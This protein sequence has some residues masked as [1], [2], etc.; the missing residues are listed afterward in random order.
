M[1]EWGPLE[2]GQMT[3]KYLKTRS[4]WRFLYFLCPRHQ[5]S[6]VD[7][8]RSNNR[9]FIPLYLPRP[10]VCFVVG[11]KFQIW[12]NHPNDEVHGRLLPLW[13]WLEVLGLGPNGNCRNRLFRVIFSLRRK[14]FCSVKFGWLVSYSRGAGRRIGNKDVGVVLGEKKITRD[15]LSFLQKLQGKSGKGR[16]RG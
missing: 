8:I 15:S 3:L 12:L 14:L 11:W 6:P 1:Y 7:H 5:N 10:K 16:T 13:S 9:V 2:R 4:K